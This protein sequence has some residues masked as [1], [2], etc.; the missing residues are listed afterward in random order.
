V[1]WTVFLYVLIHATQLNYLEARLGVTFLEAED[2]EAEDGG[3]MNEGEAAPAT[4]P[5][6][7]TA[8]AAAA[9]TAAATTASV[10]FPSL[11]R[12]LGP[13]RSSYYNSEGRLEEASDW[14]A[15][16]EAFV[17]YLS[18]S[19]AS[20]ISRASGGGVGLLASAD[21]GP[22]LGSGGLLLPPL[23]IPAVHPPPHAIP[24]PLR[25]ASG[26]RRGGGG[27]KAV[28]AQEEQVG[29]VR[30]MGERLTRLEGKLDA[31]LLR[32]LPAAGQEGPVEPATI[33]PE[34]PLLA[35]GAT[36]TAAQSD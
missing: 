33:P 1:K 34:P 19:S 28:A 12:R 23:I 27:A 16:D 31:L 26:G 21:G 8:A 4:A 5:T 35:S 13:V 9:E 10:S 25:A 15:A 2:A 22:L 14:T 29:A 30:E 7:T 3:D 36:T 20:T 18:D 17:G 24:F 11:S 32:L 6:T